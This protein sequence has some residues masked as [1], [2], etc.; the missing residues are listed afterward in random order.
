PHY[1]V[2]IID[3]LPNNNIPLWFHCASKD[4]DL[5]YHNPK[6]GD[7][8]HFRFNMHLFKHTLFFCHF[9][10]GKKQNAFDVFTQDL[11]NNCSGDLPIYYCYWKV[12]EDGFYMGPQLSQLKKLHD[13]S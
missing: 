12:Q 11:A 3:A 10:W 5:G 4:D 13:W 2:H 7:D 6:V 8:F 9:W 1:E